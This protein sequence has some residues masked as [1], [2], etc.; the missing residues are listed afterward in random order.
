MAPITVIIP[1]SPIP[2][3]PATDTI[4]KVIASVKRHLP[5]SEIIVMCDGVRPSVAGRTAQYDG[6]KDNLRTYGVEIREFDQPMQQAR[7]VRAVL[8]E[9]KTEL[10]MF[11]EHDIVLDEKEID[12]K[13]IKELA[14]QG[15][16]VRPY[17]NQGI[18]PEHEYLMRG[19]LE[20]G[21]VKTVQFSGWV[22][23]CRKDYLQRM[24]DV[25]G[26]QNAM[27]ETPLYSVMSE[28][29][30]EAWRQVIYLPEGNTVR[31]HH[32]DGRQGDAKEW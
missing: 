32:L 12:W 19:E 8:P 25:I 14:A 11:I 28:Q 20:P 15:Y 23:M 29:P 22:F 13:R 7:M 4:G 27:L 6:Y 2:E 30:W 18:H 24:V 1:T 10:V 17:W 26:E 9:V 31:F 3:H 16:L 21:F 5:G